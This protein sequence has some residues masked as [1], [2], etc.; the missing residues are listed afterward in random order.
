MANPSVTA[1]TTPALNASHES[2]GE[3]WAYN[4]GGVHFI[5]LYA[6][7]GGRKWG[8]PHHVTFN[9][10]GVPAI[11]GAWDFARLGVS[12]AGLMILPSGAVKVRP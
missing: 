8:L 3:V 4:D 9:E 5:V 2:V 10:Y 6:D 7:S 12:G 1:P 11:V